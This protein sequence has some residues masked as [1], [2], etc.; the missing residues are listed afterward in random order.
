VAREEATPKDAAWARKRVFSDAAGTGERDQPV[1]RVV[2]EREQF[3]DLGV[4]SDESSQVQRQTLSQI[5][6]GRRRR[7]RG[8]DGRLRP[9]RFRDGDAPARTERPADFFQPVTLG[10][11]PVL[12]ERGQKR[13]AGTQFEGAFFV[14]DSYRNLEVPHIRGNHLRTERNRL[15]A[16][17]QH[18]SLRGAGRLQDATQRGK[19]NSQTAPTF[20][21][22]ASGHSRSIITS[23]GYRRPGDKASRA[24]NAAVFCVGNRTIGAPSPGYTVKPP[25]RWTRIPSLIIFSLYDTCRE[26]SKRREWTAKR[27]I[28]LLP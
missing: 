13:P 15:A 17:D 19:R 6:P 26:R 2:P 21:M 23:R 12:V 8:C 14:P 20:S 10:Q 16:G 3:F 24:S 11:N 28:N 9:R 18:R 1:R 5:T 7:R 27:V 25:N 22:E 4:S